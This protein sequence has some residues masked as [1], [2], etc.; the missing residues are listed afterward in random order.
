[1][2]CV[3]GALS[4]SEKLSSLSPPGPWVAI[5]GRCRTPAAA[6]MIVEWP[7]TTTYFRLS[8]LLANPREKGDTFCKRGLMCFRE[9]SWTIVF[10]N[11]TSST[12]ELSLPLNKLVLPLDDV[13]KW[14]TVP[15]QR[16]LSTIAPANLRLRFFV[17]LTQRF[18]TFPFLSR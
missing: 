6:D 15:L 17:C 11:S 16:N 14:V 9:S 12:P 5:N 3:S 4:S 1:M 13:C 7:P 8:S 10:I 18:F 2:S